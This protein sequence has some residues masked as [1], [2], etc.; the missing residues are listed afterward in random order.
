RLCRLSLLSSVSS[1]FRPSPVARWPGRLCPRRVGN[2]GPRAEGVRASRPGFKEPPGPLHYHYS[3]NEVFVNSGSCNIFQDF[4]IFS[5]LL[6]LPESDSWRILQSSPV[7]RMTAMQ[8]GVLMSRLRQGAGLTQAS[9]ADRAGLSLRTVQSW[10]QGRRVPVSPDFFKLVAA[11]GVPADAFAG[12]AAAS[13][14]TSGPSGQKKPA[15]GKGR[16]D[17]VGKKGA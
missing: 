6:I 3:T 16:K 8:F 7:G 12:I 17:K 4:S 14:V 1:C 10:E 2:T 9:L 5:A 15:A 11:L 13:K